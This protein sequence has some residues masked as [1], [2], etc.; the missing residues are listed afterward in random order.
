MK[1][2]LSRHRIEFST[3]FLTD[4]ANRQ[5]VQR[6]GGGNAPLTL[7][8]EEQVWGFEPEKLRSALERAGLTSGDRRLGD[9]SRTDDVAPLAVPLEGS[10]AVA[11]FLDNSLT[12]LSSESGTYLVGGMESSTVPL[13]GHPIV[14]EPCPLGDTLAVV[15]YEGGSVTFLSLTDGS[16]VRGTYEAST[17]PSGVLPLHAVAHPEL[18]LLYVSNSE[19]QDLTVFD[20]SKADYAFGSREQSSVRLPGKPGTMAIDAK[21]EILYV[22]VRQGGVV[23]LNARSLTPWTG[24]LA[25]STF[26]T[27]GG[28]GIALAADGERVFVPEALGTAEGLGVYRAESGVPLHS[29][30]DSSALPSGAV[31]FAVAAHPSRPIVYVSCFGPQRIEFRDARSGEYLLGSAESSSVEVGAGARAMLVDPDREVLYVS[32]F[33]EGSVIMLDA[34][35]ARYR[36]D[37]RAASTV[38]TGSGPRGLALVPR[39]ASEG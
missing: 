32:C 21:G 20:P 11:N 14:V 27:G 38:Q 2:F 24:D 19:S 37:T 8:G 28:R 26:S 35:T 15:N 9:T 34:T 5:E 1:E 7:I 13:D 12:F 16:F 29:T 30:R 18:P 25:T 4:E 36:N 3:R 31:P 10:V 22:R 6:R 17:R 23:M 33:D 39:A